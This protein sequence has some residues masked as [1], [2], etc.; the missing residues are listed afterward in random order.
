MAATMESDA[1]PLSTCYGGGSKQAAKQQLA[2]RWR[3]RWLW[4]WRAASQ[5]RSQGGLSSLRL[6]RLDGKARASR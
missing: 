4:L 3:W 1:L 2:R 5:S 6:A